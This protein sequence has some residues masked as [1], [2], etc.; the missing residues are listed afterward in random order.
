MAAEVEMKLTRRAKW[1]TACVLGSWTFFVVQS[2]FMV[3]PPLLGDTIHFLGFSASLLWGILI[4]GSDPRTLTT[5]PLPRHVW[6]RVRALVYAF[7]CWAVASPYFALVGQWH[8]EEFSYARVCARIEP[9]AH[10]IDRFASTEGR[11][12]KSLAELVPAY[13]PEEPRAGVS[14]CPDWEYEVRDVAIEGATP[15]GP[16][17][18]RSEWRIW[19][20]CRMIDSL[21]CSVPSGC[22]IPRTKASAECRVD[23]E[24]W[25]S[26]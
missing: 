26:D 4:F 5:P 1:G 22:G 16:V 10:A 17:S 8:L 6:V 13:L 11:L 15:D 9:A 14:G 18:Y 20:K 25:G 23:C 12:P 24:R 19:F 2:L 3:I 21:H 7:A